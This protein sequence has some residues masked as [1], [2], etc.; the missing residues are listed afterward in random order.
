MTKFKEFTLEI[1]IN[2]S[3][4]EVWD[5]LF[6]RFGEVN[7]F[8]PVIEGSHHTTGAKGEVG[9]ER[10]CDINS[11][12]SVH[13]KI[14]AARGNDGFD[15]EL[16]KGRMPFMDKMEGTWEFKELNQNQTRA[17]LTMRLK[18]KP[19][20]MSS[21]MKGMMSKMVGSMLV[22]LKYHLETGNL[23]TKE[24]IKNIMKEYKKLGTNEA[25]ATFQHVPKV[26]QV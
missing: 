22:G 2:S 17:F 9:C 12:T 4:E 20:F 19:A 24:N 21:L 25:F 5:L 14:T 3:K 13:E 1:N 7:L 18:T 6:N 11:R 10:Q 16:I 8:N 26:A 15:I 23:V